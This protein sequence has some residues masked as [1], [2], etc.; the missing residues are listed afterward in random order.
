MAP[1]GEPQRARLTRQGQITVPRA[2]REALGAHPGDD[3][4]FEQRGE[5]IVV[6]HRPRKSILDFAGI[7]AVT[8]PAGELTQE[9]ID[10]AIEDAVHE[11]YLAKERRI[12]ASRQEP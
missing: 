6:R 10:A 9:A 11:S 12:A 2:V 7:A 4:L 1:Y 3:L 8:A 5:E